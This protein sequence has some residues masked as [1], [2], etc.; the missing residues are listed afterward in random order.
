MPENVFKTA[1]DLS[2]YFA[3]LE[4]FHSA[5]IRAHMVTQ[6]MW[7]QASRTSDTGRTMYINNEPWAATA[8]IQHLVDN[9]QIK[10]EATLPPDDGDDPMEVVA[11]KQMIEDVVSCILLQTDERLHKR[12]RNTLKKEMT[13]DMAVLGWYAGIALVL[14][15]AK[16]DPWFVDNWSPTDTFP[17][18]Q[19]GTALVHRSRMTAR[20]IEKT[21]GPKRPGK[22]IKGYKFK[23]SED[24]DKSIRYA[25][26]DY[27]D[28][29]T[30]MAIAM[31]SAEPQMLKPQLL[32]GCDHNPAWCNPVNAVPARYTST[33][34]KGETLTAPDS[35]TNRWMAF[36]GQTPMYGYLNAYRNV[37][38]F[39]NQVAQVLEQW[40]DVKVVVVSQDG[41]HR[42]VDLNKRDGSIV[43]NLKEGERLDIL[44]P[45]AFPAPLK[46][47]LMFLLGEVQK[48]S[49]PAVA[50]G[51]VGATEA[52]GALQILQQSSGYIVGPI[53]AEVQRCHHQFI[54]SLV[55]QAEGA[56][57]KQYTKSHPM[58]VQDKKGK[59]AYKHI[60]LA[61]MPKG[62]KIAVE[63]KGAGFGPDKL[64]LLA[65][66]NQVSNSPNPVVDDVVLLEDYLDRDDVPEILERKL[67]QKLTTHQG[68]IEALGPI[69]TALRLHLEYKKRADAGGGEVSKIMADMTI[70]V[71]QAGVMKLQEL[72]SPPE[73]PQDPQAAVL[74]AIQGQG[75]GQPGMDGS[76][77]VT[78]T[79]APGAPPTGIPQPPTGPAP[80]R[81]A[82]MAAAQAAQGGAPVTY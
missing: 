31:V 23:P 45:S 28:D 56:K 19:G 29:E 26:Y 24:A 52:T 54:N 47:W 22:A 21:F 30:N 17:D 35:E 16:G 18:M 20:E 73:Q 9:G 25:V 34:D 58:L 71:A 64:G 66:T 55:R 59:Q 38:E 70:A 62:A 69:T 5:R 42:E 41:K 78:G 13:W 46:D 37:S 68:V 33:N 74:A 32:H 51:Q 2:E 10:A 65:A 79:A 57:G 76:S 4:N 8:L 44:A 40:A 72:V 63:I 75:Q 15:N 82:E 50:Y 12:R 43:A 61:E 36:V 39:A 3:R 11:R 6:T 81:G 80:S 7:E 48:A 49:F 27:W 53:A 77:Q 60:T 14:D 1:S 67:E